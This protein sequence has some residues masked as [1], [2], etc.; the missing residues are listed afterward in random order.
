MLRIFLH[1]DTKEKHYWFEGVRL[2]F[3]VLIAAW[4][5]IYAQTEGRANW[6]YTL[7]QGAVLA[8]LVLVPLSLVRMAVIRRN[9]NVQDDIMPPRPSSKCHKWGAVPYPAKTVLERFCSVNRI[10]EL[11]VAVNDG[12]Y[13]LQVV[14]QEGSEPRVY[15][16]EHETHHSIESLFNTL[17]HVGAI[18]AEGLIRILSVDGMAPLDFL[19]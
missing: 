8:I 6:V 10:T 11:D 12:F 19:S 4:S 9:R 1:G 2:T 17:M 14:P 13:A 18:D 16:F 3:L 5:V 7:L 15:H